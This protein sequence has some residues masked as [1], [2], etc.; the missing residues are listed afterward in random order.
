MDPANTQY[1]GFMALQMG[2]NAAL[3]PAYLPES[4][5]AKGIN[6]D[7]RGGLIRTRSGFRQVAQLPDGI[8]NGAGRWSLN[9]GDRIV[10]GIQGD[11]H[12]LSA[13][14]GA[15][16]FTLSGALSETHA[17]Y[18]CQAD[19]FLIV[20]DGESTPV[21]LQY[22]DNAYSQVTEDVSIPIGYMMTYAHGRLHMVPKFVPSTTTDGRPYIIS[23]DI[24]EPDNPATCLQF[25]EVEYL[26]EGGAHGLP[27]ELGFIGGIAPLRNAQTG[28]GVGGTIVLAK[29]GS[30]GF[31]FSIPRA[32]WKS[33]ALSQVLFFGGG[34]VSPR[35][36]INLNND[37]LY[38]GFDGIRTLRHTASQAGGGGALSNVPVAMEMVPYMDTG[39]ENL[40]NAAMAGFDNQI[41]LTTQFT[42]AGYQALVSWDTAAGYFIGASG[43]GAY[44]GIWTGA[45]FTQVLSA[46][47]NNTE[48]LFAFTNS[49][50]MY[51]LDP[52][53][54]KDEG[55][56]IHSR[57]ETRIYPFGDFLTRK[58]LM[59][60][61]MWLTGISRQV[62][63]RMHYKPFGYPKWF[64]LGQERTINVPND[65]MSQSRLQLRFAVDNS[66]D[67]CDPVSGF[68]PTVAVGFQ[69]AI[70]WEGDLTLER[71]RAASQP[72]MD[73]PPEPCD[74]DAVM[75]SAADSET[76]VVLGDFGYN[77]EA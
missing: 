26:S 22:D 1:D 21:I 14:T 3:N 18:F 65:S 31:D 55:S 40:Y 6:V 69:F 76:G 34:T 49:N 57:I 43:P 17:Y 46:F 53:D 23:G 15:V 45:Q 64:T 58:K 7:V 29:N 37:L 39:A 50:R 19:R 51:I 52:Y 70:S 47:R 44:N 75:L 59:Y 16:V 13:D 67:I 63:V 20:Q 72:V 24:C 28:T 56:E 8:F 61:E 66:Q 27:N 5:Y 48:S 2:M 41:L 25:T 4:Q 62:K 12:V 33:Q 68:L 30:C 35:S 60:A 54:R 10:V 71:F 36:V 11:L 77:M 38:R 32:Q 9:S 73:A 74:A 42:G